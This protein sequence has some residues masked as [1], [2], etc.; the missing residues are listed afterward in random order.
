MNEAE[1]RKQLLLKMYD[2]M[3]NDI[4]RHILVVW[5]ALGVVI[6]AFAIFS[7][8]EKNVL[9]LDIAVALIVLLCG[10]MLAQL[11][12]SAYWYNRNLVIIANIEREMLQEEDLTR[13]HFYFGSHRPQ[14]KM[15]FHLRIQ[16]YLGISVALL[17]LAYHFHVARIW[18]GF[19]LPFG[20]FNLMK[21]LPY[22]ALL[23]A[24]TFV[25]YTRNDRA[26]AY[27]YFVRRSPGKPMPESDTETPGHTM[28]RDWLSQMWLALRLYRKD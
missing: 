22:L 10:W 7:L 28:M 25:N 18:S 19:S 8:T 27:A 11:Y 17:V 5:Q 24:I 9:P 13:I 15:L 21:A 26:D 6:G 14:N 20:T 23:F 1:A 2:Q 16:R 4:N 3:F 12:D